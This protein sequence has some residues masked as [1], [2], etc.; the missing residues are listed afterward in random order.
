MMK[1]NI[2][3]IDPAPDAEWE[4]WYEDTFDRECPRQVEVAG[5]GLAKGLMELWARHLFETVQPNGQKGFSRFNLWRKQKE[6]SI[7]IVGTWAGSTRL[8]EWVFGDRRRAREGY[9]KDGDEDLLA[10]L[11]VTHTNLILAGRTSEVVLDAAGA[12]VDQEDF[13]ARL[14]ALGF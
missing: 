13:E 10:K 14:N 12:S 2:E 1:P 7:E 11:A 8:R 3:L 9:V 6:Q 5:L 4:I